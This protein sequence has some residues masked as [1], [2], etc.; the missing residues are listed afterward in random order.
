MC[1]YAYLSIE[2]FRPT[3]VWF[4]HWSTMSDLGLLTQDSY[5]RDQN[6]HHNKP[7][8][9]EDDQLSLARWLHVVWDVDC[10]RVRSHWSLGGS[11]QTKTIQEGEYKIRDSEQG[12]HT[13]RVPRPYEPTT[14]CDPKL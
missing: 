11:C 3:D 1:Y 9:T 2:M 13:N 6:E 4:V 7:H 12:P 14:I 10:R 5:T 8:N